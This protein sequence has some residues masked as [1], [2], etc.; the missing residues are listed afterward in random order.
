MGVEDPGPEN[1]MHED[2]EK[3]TRHAGMQRVRWRA[4]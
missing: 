3:L 2:F 4:V 1:N